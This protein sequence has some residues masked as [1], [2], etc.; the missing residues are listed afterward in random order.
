MSVKDVYDSDDSDYE[1]ETEDRM[2]ILKFL[3]EANLTLLILIM[4]INWTGDTVVIRDTGMH[5]LT[6]LLYSAVFFGSCAA[7]Q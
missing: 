7:R 1:D 5:W 4:E 6:D 3:D 2:Q